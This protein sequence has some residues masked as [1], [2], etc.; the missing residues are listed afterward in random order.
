MQSYSHHDFSANSA[1]CKTSCS[2]NN[3]DVVYIEDRWPIAKACISEATSQKNAKYGEQTR[4]V[5]SSLTGRT[6]NRVDIRGNMVSNK[7]T[8]SLNSHVNHRADDRRCARTRHECTNTIV[9]APRLY[10]HLAFLHQS[11]HSRSSLV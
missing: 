9:N 4:A 8:N 11:H 6:V 5:G 1:T 7:Q 2:S 3:H 10:I